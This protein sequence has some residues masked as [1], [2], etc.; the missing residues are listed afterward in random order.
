MF[1]SVIILPY[2]YNYDTLVKFLPKFLIFIIAI[3]YNYIYDFS[4]LKIVIN[5]YKKIV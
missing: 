1:L 2:I 4:D 5:N 3:I